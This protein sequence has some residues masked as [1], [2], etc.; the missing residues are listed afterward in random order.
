MSYE[1]Q[2]IYPTDLLKN[3]YKPLVEA[4]MICECSVN[5]IVEA[6]N[7]RELRYAEFRIEGSHRRVPHVNPDDLKKYLDRR[8]ASNGT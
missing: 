3:K 5:T 8:K 4:A 6:I 2:Q 7:K 1:E